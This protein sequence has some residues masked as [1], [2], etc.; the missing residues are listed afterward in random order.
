MI[1]LIPIRNT[2][3]LDARI[4]KSIKA[5]SIAT[6]IGTVEN[7]PVSTLKRKGEFE[8]RDKIV[9]MCAEIK[10]DYVVTQDSDTQHLFT[11]N[12]ECMKKFLDNNKDVGMV[13]LWW[14]E[15][16]RA[17]CPIQSA[18][19]KLSCAMWR[20][21]VLAQMPIL[22]NA[23]TNYDECCCFTYEKA[24]GALSFRA[25]YLDDMK[26]IKDLN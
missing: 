13:S 23:D 14:L 1:V 24:I 2:D 11:D 17:N 22:I 26:R 5:Q 18:H 8:G 12:I 19:V 6:Q 10:D 15:A 7:S 25:T 20:T 3:V 4:S 21:I 16:P 9:R